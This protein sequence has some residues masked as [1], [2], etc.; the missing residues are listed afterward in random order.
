MAALAIVAAWLL[1]P[2]L[3]AQHLEGYTTNLKVIAFM[4]NRGDPLGQD[5][6]TPSLTEF[7]YYSRAGVIGLLRVGEA[8]VGPAT[9][10][11]FRAIMIASLAIILAGSVYIARKLE[12]V[13]PI[14]A[15]ATLLLIPGV[16]ESAFFFND[17]LPSAAFAIAGVALAVAWDR[18]ASYLGAGILS[19]AAVLCRLD[20]LLLAPAIGG[21]A[22]LRHPAWRPFLARGTAAV[23]GFAV[24]LA[25]AALLLKATPLDV[26][27]VSGPFTPH[28]RTFTTV[29]IL[30]FFVGVPG[31]LLLAVGLPTS[32]QRFAAAP[33]RWRRIFVLIIYPAL[34]MIIMFRLSTELRYIYPLLT[35]FVA[36]YG[37]R[38]LEVLVASLRTRHR[39]SA[40]A[41]LVVL[42]LAALLPPVVTVVRDGPR[43][44]VGR[45]WM[46]VLWWQWHDAMA[47]S[48]GRVEEAARQAG[49][50][51]LTLVIS[52]HFNDDFFWK[53]RLLAAGWR[54]RPAERVFP[55]CSGFSAYEKDGSLI[56]H[57]RTERQYGQIR[58]A[59]SRLRAFMIDRGL[60][61]PALRAADRTLFTAWG[62]DVRVNHFHDTLDPRVVGSVIPRFE[63]L[64]ALSM[65]FTPADALRL[66]LST[67]RPAD[68]SIHRRQLQ[69]AYHQRELSRGEVDRLA[70][71]AAAYL[72][73]PRQA[74]RDLPDVPVTWAE[75]LAA[76]R[77]RCLDPDRSD[78]REIP[79][80]LNGPG[81][82][83]PTG[84]PYVAPP[85]T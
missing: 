12:S 63:P 74:K 68:A 54:I 13:R 72:R 5:L 55:G 47:G 6:L 26:L 45:L 19:A 42:A 37:G 11:D 79:L 49:R 27:I 57:I 2:V 70:R 59:K 7:L 44:P 84:E 76:Y 18:P 64:A 50:T 28:P 21:V 29:L 40:Q 9:D 36:L 73:L 69:G 56:A 22:L 15:F 48:L 60:A 25:L 39:P 4:A 16:T 41:G 67:A 30:A 46:P 66:P 17:N 85:K 61:C 58:V 1:S 24:G 71:D 3:R 14:A 80:C 51:P 52:T 33:D 81:R 8:L 75:Y 77:P 82:R 20:A 78:W 35:P 83:T 34:I 43:S 65:R 62:D 10:W 53:Q 31:A 32:W 38:G 23:V